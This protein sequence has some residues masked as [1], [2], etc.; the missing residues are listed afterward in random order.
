[1]PALTGDQLLAKAQ[2][3]RDIADQAQRDGKDDLATTCRAEAVSCEKQA[4]GFA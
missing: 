2:E 4:G 3:W 1:M